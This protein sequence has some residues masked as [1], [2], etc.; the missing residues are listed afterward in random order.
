MMQMFIHTQAM[1]CHSQAFI[2]GYVSVPKY[3]IHLK[4]YQDKFLYFSHQRSHFILNSLLVRSFYFSFSFLFIFSPLW[5]LF[6]LVSISYNHFFIFPYNHV[7]KCD[8]AILWTCIFHVHSHSMTRL[9]FYYIVKKQFFENLESS[10]IFVNLK[11]K[12]KIRN[13]TLV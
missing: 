5:N 8:N 12:N 11:K 3:T 6:I 9:V 13:K 7:G 4:S 10:L 1:H 2:E